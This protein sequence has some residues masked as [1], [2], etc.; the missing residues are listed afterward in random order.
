VNEPFIN[1]EEKIDKIV[2]RRT[3]RP[4]ALSLETSRKA[5]SIAWRK[6]LGGVRVPRGV[7]RFR[8]HE[9]ADEWLWHMIA[10]PRPS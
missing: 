3:H 10:R 2:G 8:T 1:A 4:D 7:H 5:D 9:E 6:A